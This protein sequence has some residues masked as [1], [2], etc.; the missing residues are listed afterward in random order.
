MARILLLG[1]F[2]AGNFGDEALLADWLIR[3][4]RFFRD[5]NFDIDV[6]V[7]GDKLPDPVAVFRLD[8]D[9]VIIMAETIN[10]PAE[11]NFSRVAI[12][13]GLKLDPARLRDIAIPIKDCIVQSEQTEENLCRA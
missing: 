9:D 1:Y 2:G 5:Q 10:A 3:H 12:G 7:R 4:G 8:A 6:V 11:F 13:Q